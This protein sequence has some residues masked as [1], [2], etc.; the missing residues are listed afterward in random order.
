V[1]GLWDCTATSEALGPSLTRALRSMTGPGVSIFFWVS[2]C[3][4]NGFPD[5]EIPH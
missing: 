4:K 5:L 1:A 3:L 2:P